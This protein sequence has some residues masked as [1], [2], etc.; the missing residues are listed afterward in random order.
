MIGAGG[1]LQYLYDGRVYKIAE[2]V[3]GIV[4]ASVT[5]S[6]IPGTY[7][8]LVIPW[9]ARGDN[10]TA[11]TALVMQAN[12]DTTANYDSE[13]YQFHGSVSG[14]FVQELIGTA[15]P[16]VGDLAAAS[17]P[18][19]FAG[20]GVIE[21]QNYAGTTFNKQ[22]T[23]RSAFKGANTTGNINHEIEAWFWRNSAAI[24]AIK[25]LPGAGNFVAGSM[26]Q[27]YGCN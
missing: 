26:F 18:A 13:L 11:S 19:G 10:A 15:T 16:A 14:P 24:T 7:R 6:S 12:G 3:L 21:I 17:A 8:H 25:L 5:F 1:N 22:A 23:G 20:G 4:T 27:L 9:G 2:F